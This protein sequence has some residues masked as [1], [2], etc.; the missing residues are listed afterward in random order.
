MTVAGVAEL[1]ASFNALNF[2]ENKASTIS[3]HVAFGVPLSV[4][5]RIHLL[6]GFG[7]GP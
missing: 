1:S 4:P 7:G 6:S 2:L 5:E 3:M